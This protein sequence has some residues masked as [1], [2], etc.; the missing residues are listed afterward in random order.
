MAKTLMV[1]NNV[2]DEL[3]KLKENADKSFSEVIVDL[4]SRKESKTAYNL[5][6]HLGALKGDAE[7]KKLEKE[8]KAGWSKWQRK[9]A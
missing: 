5:M 6:K 2:Y 1:S 7:Y 4:I 8:I 3:R 9:Y